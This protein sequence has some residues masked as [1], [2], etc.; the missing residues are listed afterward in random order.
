MLRLADVPSDWWGTR[1]PQRFCE[2]AKRGGKIV[3]G[4]CEPIENHVNR[5]L[6]KVWKHLP[7]PAPT[8]PWELLPSRRLLLI[9]VTFP[10]KLQ[11]LKLRHC[12][13]VLTSLPNFLWI[14]AEDAA[15]PTADVAA[16]LRGSGLPHEHL[17]YGPTRK[18]GNAQRNAALELI[19]ARQLQG[20]V[21]QMDDDNAYH[22]DLWAGLRRL[23]PRRVGVLGVRRGVYPPHAC[24]GVFYP[25][26]R[27][28]KVRDHM[29]ERP[30]YNESTGR[31]AGF[32]AG[33]CDSRSWLWKH[34]GGRRFCVDMGGFVFDAALLSHVAGAIWNYT[35]HG[36][37][38]ELLATL[39]G[40]D[41]APEDL[42]PLANCGQDI[43]VFHN[44][45]ARRTGPPCHCSVPGA[46]LPPQAPHRPP[47]A[48]GSPNPLASA[49]GTARS[50]LPSG[51]PECAA[52][53]MGG[54]WPMT[55]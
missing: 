44:E 48:P 37:E 4:K 19:R 5:T 12:I 43:L 17:A 23:R 18:G 45:C 31:F 13:A 42:Q 8:S 9:T 26:P 39:L 6:S 52:Q 49:A 29:I 25:L 53:P 3:Q 32:S 16:L 27:G 36:G 55:R 11:L 22:P 46:T 30:T 15:S 38:S 41:S 47:T 54:G 51:D 21:Y 24:D 40:P 50:R 14:V 2:R 33:W 7:P 34:K 20:I 28:T 35:G 10:H 1:C